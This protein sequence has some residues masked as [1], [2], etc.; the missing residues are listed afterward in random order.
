MTISYLRTGFQP[1]YIG[2][3]AIPDSMYDILDLRAGNFLPAI[4]V[5]GSGIPIR[6]LCSITSQNHAIKEGIH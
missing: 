1:G 2:D 4:Q 3:G 6:Y 5:C